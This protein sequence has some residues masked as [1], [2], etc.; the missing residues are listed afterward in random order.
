MKS[1]RYLEGVL[2]VIALL[3]AVIAWSLCSGGPNSPSFVSSAYAQAQPSVSSGDWVFLPVGNQEVRRLVIFDR[4]TKTVYDYDT[5][6]N[7]DNTW[8]IKAPGEKI[9]KTK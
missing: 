8:V 9:A 7:L 5:H 6:G 2:T 4:A 3:L 1:R